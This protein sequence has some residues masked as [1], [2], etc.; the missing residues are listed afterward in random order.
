MDLGIEI[1]TK[2]N[3][4]IPCIAAIILT[5]FIV[6][7]AVSLYRLRK[8]KGTSSKQYHI[9]SLVILVLILCAST[10][11][12]GRGMHLVHERKQDAITVTCEVLNVTFISYSPRYYYNHEATRAVWIHTTDQKYYMV[13]TGEISIGDHIEI[14]YLPNSRY[15]I[16]YKRVMQ[17][18]DS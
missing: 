13:D 7:N 6:A 18:E 14:T 16:D 8:I 17:E 11:P 3:L 1:Y 5:A 10:Y 2:Y 9:A 4:I 12:L 15:V